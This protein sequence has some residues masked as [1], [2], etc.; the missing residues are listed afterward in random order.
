MMPQ[1]ARDEMASAAAMPAAGEIDVGGSSVMR[2]ERGGAS[3][4]L[5]SI[6]LI[7]LRGVCE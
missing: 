7:E 6:P 5:T 1:S 2:V 3:R 4:H